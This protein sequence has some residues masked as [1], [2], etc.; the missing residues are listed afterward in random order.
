MDTVMNYTDLL[1]KTIS[2]V[3]GWWATLTSLR[4]KSHVELKAYV[5][6]KRPMAI[7]GIEFEVKERGCGDCNDTLDQLR[8]PD[9]LGTSTMCVSWAAGCWIKQTASINCINWNLFCKFVVCVCGRACVSVRA[10]RCGFIHVCK[11]VFL[12][13]LHLI[14]STRLCSSAAD[15]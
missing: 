1:L 2:G 5:N 7:C 9:C 10:Y 11:C 4:L 3:V 12:G 6:E 15:W 13:I 8:S 14:L